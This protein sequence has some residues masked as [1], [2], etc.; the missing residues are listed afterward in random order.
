MVS[1]NEMW[2][3]GKWGVPRENTTCPGC[4][5]QYGTY[6]RKVC[7]NCQECSKCC[8]CNKKEHVDASIAVP[9][10]LENN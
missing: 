5:H 4:N 7:L 1:D 10:I 6:K 9:I 8:Q 3:I 2:N